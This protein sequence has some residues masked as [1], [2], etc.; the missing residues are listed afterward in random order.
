M[1]PRFRCGWLGT[2]SL[3][4]GVRSRRNTK[5][6]DEDD[7]QAG[8]D[9][10][11]GVELL[12]SPDY[13]VT[14]CDRESRILTLEMESLFGMPNFY[15]CSAGNLNGLFSPTP[16]WR[17]LYGVPSRSTRKRVRLRLAPRPFVALPQPLVKSQT[18]RRTESQCP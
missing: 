3:D 18:R 7:A 4:Y 17:L 15:F 6:E 8:V 1:F 12:T 10:L 13:R 16:E 5:G 11:D 9:V 2:T 14:N